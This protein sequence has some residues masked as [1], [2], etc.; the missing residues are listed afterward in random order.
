MHEFSN[1]LGRS[2][3]RLRPATQQRVAALEVW[4]PKGP[5]FKILYDPTAI[6]SE[7]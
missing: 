1:G 2:M 3:H 4:H 6:S 7:V 5:K